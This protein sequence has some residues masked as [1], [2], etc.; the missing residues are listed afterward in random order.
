MRVI[1]LTGPA[2]LSRVLNSE[3]GMAFAVERFSEGQAGPVAHVR[4]YRFATAY[5]AFQIWSIPAD[6]YMVVTHLGGGLT[7]PDGS[8][9]LP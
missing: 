5:K 8:L 3:L 2:G 1:I 6:G 9:L 4:D 7:K